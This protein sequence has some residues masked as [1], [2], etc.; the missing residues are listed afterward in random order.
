MQPVRTN[1]ICLDLLVT[2][3]MSLGA[4]DGK[5]RNV[6]LQVIT[7]DPPG[8]NISIYLPIFILFFDANSVMGNY[9]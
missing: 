3:P 8:I 4:Y 2:L 7:E 9:I 6:R 5:V 1:W